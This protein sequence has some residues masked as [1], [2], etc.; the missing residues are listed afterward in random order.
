MSVKFLFVKLFE[1]R[2]LLHQVASHTL[3]NLSTWDKLNFITL[4]FSSIKWG[5]ICLSF[6]LAQFWKLLNEGIYIINI[7]KQSMI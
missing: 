1:F 4:V 5:T 6:S 2:S 7:V 3:T